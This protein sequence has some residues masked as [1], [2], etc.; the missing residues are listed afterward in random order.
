MAATRKTYRTISRTLYPL[1]PREE[2][3]GFKTNEALRK[4]FAD[5]K[6]KAHSTHSP[7]VVNI[8]CRG[9]KPSSATDTVRGGQ[10]AL[11]AENMHRLQRDRTLQCDGGGTEAARRHTPQTH[12]RTIREV[13][14]GYLYIYIY[15]YSIY[16]ERER[17][18]ERERETESMHIYIHIFKSKCYI[19]LFTSSDPHLTEILIEEQ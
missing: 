10:T 7:N 15:I 16:I 4:T 11:P 8:N 12:K 19:K 3:A 14:R 18:R 5:G 6:A 13:E 17:E 2:S 1:V 9:V